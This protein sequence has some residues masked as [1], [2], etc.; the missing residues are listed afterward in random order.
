MFY[1]SDVSDVFLLS[2][3]R[4]WNKIWICRISCD[5]FSLN[6]RCVYV[7]PQLLAK[8]P[9]LSQIHFALTVPFTLTSASDMV[10]LYGNDTFSILVLST[11]KQDSSFLKKV[12][13][14]Q[15]I[16]FRVEVLIRFKISRLSHKNMPISQTEGYFE[17][18]Q[19]HLLEPML[20]LLA[21]KQNLYVRALYSVKTKSQPKVCLK[22]AKR[23][24]HSFY[25][26]FDESHCSNIC[27]LQ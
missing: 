9:S 6:T 16:C 3:K 2:T 5:S 14:F 15:K 18:P 10:V 7:I 27:T 19:Y 4:R 23:S 12:S 11:K 13:V 1:S 20:F 22:L 25:C 17:N 24:N 8:L 21:L 26:L